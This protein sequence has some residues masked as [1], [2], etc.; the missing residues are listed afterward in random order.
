[1]GEGIGWEDG[2]GCRDRGVCNGA[3]GPEEG[4]RSPTRGLLWVRLAMSPGRADSLTQPQGFA[5]A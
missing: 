4:S 5:D 2:Q 1:M 3:Q